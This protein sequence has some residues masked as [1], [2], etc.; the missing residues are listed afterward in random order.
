MGI[1]ARCLGNG[2]FPYN[3][4]TNPPKIAVEW[5]DDRVEPGDD[6]YKGIHTFALL[7]VSGTT[8]T[9]KYLDQD[10]NVGFIETWT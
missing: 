5:I 3:L 1:K 2:C 4:P 8:V 7:Q 10:G 6:R 9:I